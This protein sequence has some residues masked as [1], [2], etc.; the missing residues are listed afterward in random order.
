MGL[1]W[2]ETEKR[3]VGSLVGYQ[4]HVDRKTKNYENKDSDHSRTHLNYDLMGHKASTIF[5][6]EF[7]DYIN[8]D[9]ARNRAI[10]KDAVVMQVWII[11]S[12]L[13]HPPR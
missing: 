11:S 5:K 1:W 3:K 7:M 9:K 12:R 4:I 13:V 2:H 10:R 8:E 6:H